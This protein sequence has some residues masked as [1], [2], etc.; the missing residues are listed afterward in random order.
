[1]NTK[2]LKGLS[3]KLMAGL[4]VVIMS[5]SAFAAATGAA[6]AKI[7]GEHERLEKNRASFARFSEFSPAAKKIT[8]VIFD[9]NTGKSLDIG[10]GPDVGIVT[11]ELKMQVNK[12]ASKPT[13]SFGTQKLVEAMENI[14]KL[15]KV[16][17]NKVLNNIMSSSVLQS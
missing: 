12:G 13:V 6:P 7:D 15:G 3:V 11:R 5:G 8:N 4:A 2:G 14:M 17:A 10:H 16:E 1:M 9:I